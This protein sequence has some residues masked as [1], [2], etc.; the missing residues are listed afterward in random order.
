MQEVIKLTIAEWSHIQELDYEKIPFKCLFCHGYGHFARNCKK[1]SEEELEKEKDDQ[2]TQA[3]KV[4]TSNQDPG[5]KGKDGKTMKGVIAAGKNLPNP[6]VVENASS[7]HFVV[8]STPKATSLEEGELPQLEAQNEDR[9]VNTGT[10][11]QGG[12]ANSDLPIVGESLQ[13]DHPSPNRAKSSPSYAEI[14]KKKPADSYG[15]FDEDSFEQLSK[16]VGRKSRKEARE[17]EDDR[18]KM[19]GSQ[20]TI[21]IL[22]GRS[23]KTRPHKGVINPSL[24]SK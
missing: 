16:K 15:S 11:E 5:M 4:G 7:N 19:Q 22:F 21:E 1:K 12:S 20:S 23:K 14:A 24:S 3:Q 18:L 6:H 8:L 9:K 13:E 2:W 17:E 10:M